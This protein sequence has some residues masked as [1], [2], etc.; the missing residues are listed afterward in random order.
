MFLC[1]NFFG[2]SNKLNVHDYMIGRLVDDLVLLKFKC[3]P[4]FFKKILEIFR[5]CLSK[6]LNAQKLNM[7]IFEMAHEAFPIKI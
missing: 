6:F 1:L 4:T 7:Q 5:E 2:L 3:F